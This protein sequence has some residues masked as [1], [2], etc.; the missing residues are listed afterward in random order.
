[1]GGPSKFSTSSSLAGPTSCLTSPVNACSGLWS[2]TTKKIY[3]HFRQAHHNELN[4][5]KNT[6]IFDL[7]LHILWI[8]RQGI[9]DRFVNELH[10]TSKILVWLHGQTAQP[11]RAAHVTIFHTC[12]TN[13]GSQPNAS[14]TVSLQQSWIES[15]MTRVLPEYHLLP[16]LK[17]IEWEQTLEGRLFPAKDGKPSENT[18]WN[19]LSAAAGYALKKST[20]ALRKWQASC[21]RM[22]TKIWLMHSPKAFSWVR[23]DS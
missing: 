12:C 23:A 17:T 2:A 9:A 18:L 16:S 15:S 8:C 6:D 4:T 11:H 21:Q 22:Q 3:A 7:W 19:L 20:E 13:I 1:M 14:V 5:K 10:R